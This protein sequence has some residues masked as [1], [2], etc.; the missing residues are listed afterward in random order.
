M[1]TRFHICA[2]LLLLIL[3]LLLLAIENGDA[4][5]GKKVFEQCVICHGAQGEGNDAIAKAYGVELL[6]LYSKEIQSQDD[7]SLKKVIVE[8]KGKMSPVKLSDQQ[9]NDVI[10]FLRSLKK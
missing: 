3:P 1:R 4:A 10:A 7:A 5:K 2:C 6:P 9:V 8:G